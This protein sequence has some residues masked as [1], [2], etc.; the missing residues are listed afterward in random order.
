[1]VLDN[2]RE[3][4]FP[5]SIFK[6]VIIITTYSNINEQFNVS[7]KGLTRFL[8]DSPTEIIV[9]ITKTK[10]PVDI[11]FLLN[12]DLFWIPRYNF[13]GELYELMICN[14]PGIL[15]QIKTSDKTSDDI[16]NLSGEET[17]YEKYNQLF[18]I[19]KRNLGIEE[20]KMLLRAIYSWEIS[21]YQDIEPIWRIFEN[22]IR[23]F[24][25]IR[26]SDIDSGH[27]FSTLVIPKFSQ[28]IQEGIMKRF[29]A[30][31]GQFGI[32]DIDIH[33][34]PVEYLD[35]GNYPVIIDKN[36]TTF[37]D[38]RAGGNKKFRQYIA[39]VVNA[40]APNLHNRTPDENSDLLSDIIPKILQSCEFL[41]KIE[42]RLKI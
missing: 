30:N 42:P 21:G 39:E 24:I 35:P 15:S 2:I 11:F 18:S 29:D 38:Y 9:K 7:W 41:N 12:N 37:Q 26:L 16:T 27:W 14:N 6:R 28:E 4:T 34:F 17:Y 10:I 23:N 33:P 40:R 5:I 1:M 36:P 20:R 19:N 3:P 25:Q 8:K 31:K 22:K 13:T 32:T